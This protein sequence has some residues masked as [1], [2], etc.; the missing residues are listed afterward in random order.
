MEVLFSNPDFL[1]ITWSIVPAHAD[2]NN[3]HIQSKPPLIPCR[4]WHTLLGL[5]QGWNSIQALDDIILLVSFQTLF[6]RNVVFDLDLF[7]VPGV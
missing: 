7:G 6:K 5:T 4:R 1:R 2:T 3:P